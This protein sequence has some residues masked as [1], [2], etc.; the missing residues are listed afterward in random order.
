MAN[1]LTA[2]ERVKLNEMMSDTHGVYMG[3]YHCLLSDSELLE[4]FK[5]FPYDEVKRHLSIGKYKTNS[6]W[7]HKVI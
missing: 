3:L 4:K 5:I 1:S 6:I 2:K 7:L